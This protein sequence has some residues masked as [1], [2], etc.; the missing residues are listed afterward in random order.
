MERS[1]RFIVLAATV[2]DDGIYLCRAKSDAGQAKVNISLSVLG[3]AF[4]IKS[5]VLTHC[6]IIDLKG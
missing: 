3:E 6:C 1:N 5:L 4:L 2:E